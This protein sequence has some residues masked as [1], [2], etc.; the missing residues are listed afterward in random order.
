MAHIRRTRLANEDLISIW[1]YLAKE[2][3]NLTAA[4]RVLRDIDEAVQ[5]LA[6]NPETGESAARFRADL[7]MFTKGNHIIFYRAVDDGIEVYRVLH[8]ARAWQ[9]LL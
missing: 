1:S 8:G 6:M 2:C 9:Q 3:Q 5:F 4:D 7:R